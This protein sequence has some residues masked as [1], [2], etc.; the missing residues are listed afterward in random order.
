MMGPTR[1]SGQPVTRVS[2][3]VPTQEI[4]FFYTSFLLLQLVR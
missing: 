3:E 2:H 1:A 4:T